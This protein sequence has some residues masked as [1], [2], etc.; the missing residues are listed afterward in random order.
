MVCLSSGS[1]NAFRL[2]RKGA[3]LAGRL[4]APWYAVY[5]QTPGERTERIDAATQ[6]RI[7]DSLELARQL[8]GVPLTFQGGDLPGAV[9]AFVREYG[10]T[11]VIVGR[12][13][14]P[15]YAL[16]FGPSLLERLIRAIP[17]VD[18]VVVDTSA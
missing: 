12:S 1:P 11:H 13:L 7:A 9:A 10:I 4:G 3:R 6:R 2:M 8:D 15:W 5:V 16:W 17:G 18:V 14:R